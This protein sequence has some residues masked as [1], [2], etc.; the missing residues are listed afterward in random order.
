MTSPR[1]SSH[2][3]S[4]FHVTNKSVYVWGA[5]YV[6]DSVWFFVSVSVSGEK[7]ICLVSVCVRDSDCVCV[8]MYVYI[9]FER[10]SRHTFQVHPSFEIR[11]FQLRL[12]FF[13]EL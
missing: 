12:R 4:T 10:M 5:M 13:T 8:C 9:F 1:L 3:I 7:A 6:C 11:N 2:L